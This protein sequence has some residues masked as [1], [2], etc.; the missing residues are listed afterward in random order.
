MQAEKRA[1]LERLEQAILRAQG[2]P[3]AVPDDTGFFSID[4]ELIQNVRRVMEDALEIMRQVMELYDEEKGSETPELAG[5]DEDDFLKEIG[6]AISSELAAQEVSNIAFAVRTQLMETHHA[7]NNAAQ[8]DQLWVVA[9]HADT[10]LRRAGKGLI[11]LE[12]TIREYEGLEP[13]ERTWSQLEDSQEI[14]RLYGQFRRGINKLGR[15]ETA[16]QVQH[17]LRS[18]ANRISVL[19]DR[20]IYPMMRICDR[21][22]I[23]RLQ[24]RILDWLKA[25]ESTDRHEQ[26]RRLWSDL[27]SFS[28]LLVQ[29]NHREELRGNDRRL[30]QEWLDRYFPSGTLSE[31]VPGRPAQPEHLK[32]LEA[33]LGRS[34]ELDELIYNPTGCTLE[35]LKVPMSRIYQELNRPYEPVEEPLTSLM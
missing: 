33:L 13:I 21:L 15:P 14:R 11:T 34:D 32:E 22:P 26:G 23:R 12:N 9:S 25:P 4:S 8:G 35:A 6:A 3:F 29:I 16:D 2:I 31:E 18:A 27:M 20:K 10:G 28:E 17:A 30:I 5:E 1:V 7:L 19:R 24:K